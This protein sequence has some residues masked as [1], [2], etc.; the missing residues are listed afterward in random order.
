MIVRDLFSVMNTDTPRILIYDYDNNV[1]YSKYSNKPIGKLSV[2]DKVVA[3][4]YRA[5][6][7]EIAIRLEKE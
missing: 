2:W 3:W 5:D 7:T 4:I 6:S 1:I